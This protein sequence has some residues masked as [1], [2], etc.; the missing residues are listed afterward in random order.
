MMQRAEI[1]PGVAVQFLETAFQPDDW[2]AVFLKNQRSGRVAQRVAP[3]TTIATARF[4]DWLIREN[5][6]GASVYVS[7]S[8]LQ[9]RTTVRRRQAVGT[10]RHVFLDAD[11]DLDELLTAV[12]VR[13]D[14]PEPSYVIRTSDNRGHVFW[15]AIAFP[16]DRAE[17]LEKQLARELQTDVAA[18]AS[19]QLTRLPGYLN[20]KRAP[21]CCV[22]IHYGAAT[23]ALYTPDDFPQ[24]KC[25]TCAPRD[26][27]VRRSP[28]PGADMLV[29]AQ[30]Y[31]AAVPPAISGQ[32]G[33]AH[34]FRV[35][36]RL[37][38]GFALSDAD[39]L[40]LLNEWNASCRPPWSDRELADKLRRARRYGREPIGG[41]L[42]DQV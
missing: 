39:A 7:V 18:T 4:Q 3:R 2:L 40:S 9:P 19:S 11:R 16:I 23:H 36:C 30:R 38:R 14:L 12:A 31:L 5:R 21:A 1:D 32:H 42:G 15:R 8:A 13:G 29:R 37:A 35:C 26:A 17:A 22:T 10:I 28:A 24:P 27:P 20:H 6:A 33:D 34:T 41:L 25:C